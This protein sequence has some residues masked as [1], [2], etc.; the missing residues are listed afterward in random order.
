MQNLALTFDSELTVR[1]AI[2]KVLSVLDCKA[3]LSTDNRLY[4][5]AVLSEE[6]FELVKSE[7]AVFGI[8]IAEEKSF[9]IVDN[10]KIVL[11][12]YVK[13]TEIR[14]KKVSA[15]L[16]DTFGYSYSHLSHVFSRSTFMTIENFLIM[17]K[18]ERA[19][20]LLLEEGKSLTD[21]AYEMDYSSVAH[22]SRQ[23]KK[24]TGLTVTEFINI[25][26][27]LALNK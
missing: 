13:S 3:R 12:S 25:K 5:D 11:H 8:T 20:L 19:K 6:E 1:M 10:I 21:V 22:L 17:L 18:I 26:N 14:S 7:L 15:M 23:F 27:S 4:F 16:V 24:I 9:D 2:K